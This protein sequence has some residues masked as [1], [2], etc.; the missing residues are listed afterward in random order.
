MPRAVIIVNPTAGHGRAAKNWNRLR[1]LADSYGDYEVKRTEAPG[2][3]RDLASDAARRGA[4]RVIVFGGDGT[5]NEVGNGL[6]G[7]TTAMAVVPTGSAND[8]F[9]YLEQPLDLEAALGLAF[10]GR[11]LRSD[12]GLAVGHRHFFNVCGIGFDATVARRVNAAGPVLKNIPGT[13]PTVLMV[14]V[15]LLTYRGPRLTAQ[16]DDQAPVTIDQLFLAEAGVGRYTGGGMKILPDAVLDDGWFDMMLVSGIRRAEV[17]GLL[18]RIYKGAHTGHPKLSFSR[19]RRLTIEA[20]R[21]LAFHLDGED[22][23]N[24]PVTLELVPAALDVIVPLSAGVMVPPA[25]G[26]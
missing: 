12:A 11:R 19:V 22:V 21:P 25:A 17:L 9:R 1:P 26:A 2:H 4:D 13:L 20:D 16:V 10:G 24:L 5:I 7:T 6:V 15:T 3:A 18:A 23:G 8:W 14:L